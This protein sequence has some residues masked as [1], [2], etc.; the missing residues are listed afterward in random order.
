MKP[1]SLRKKLQDLSGRRSNSNLP[2]KERL[3]LNKL[4]SKEPDVKR[5][6]ELLLKLNARREKLRLRPSESKERKNLRRED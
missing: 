1:D 6:Q 4:D 3:Q 2:L 5:R